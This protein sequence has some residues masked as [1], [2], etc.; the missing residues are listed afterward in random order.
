MMLRRKMRTGLARDTRGNTIVEF[1]FIAPV[2]LLMFMGFFDLCY[3]QY[4]TS[5]L[6][7]VVEKAGRDSTLEDGPNKITAIDNRVRELSGQVNKDA[8]YTFSRKSFKKF[9][10]VNQLEPFTDANNNGSYDVGECF[11]DHNLSGSRDLFVGKDGQG[12]ADDVVVYVVQATY[13]RLFPMYGL[14]GWTQNNVVTAQTVL[15]NQP[16]AD[17]AKVVCAP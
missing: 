13:P 6:R 15:R 2:L 12:G 7:G 11:E 4:F 1:A 16:Y 10:D 14:L 8:T 5:V 9:G 17:Q 3:Q